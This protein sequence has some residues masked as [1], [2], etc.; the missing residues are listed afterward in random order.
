MTSQPGNAWAKPGSQRYPN[1]YTVGRWPGSA[2]PAGLLPSGTRG[3]A[4]LAGRSLCFVL[5]LA[6]LLISPMAAWAR[7]EEPAV[8]KTIGHFLTPAMLQSFFPGADRVGGTEGTPPAAAVYKADRLIGYIFSTWDVTRSRGFADRPLVL[9]VGLDLTGRITGAKL[10]QHNEAIGILGLRDEDFR[11]FPEQFAGFNVNGGTVVVQ[12]PALMSSGRGDASRQQA[13]QQAQVDA[14]AHAT[15]SSVMMSDAIIRGARIVA[16][17]RGIAGAASSQRRVDIDRFEPADWR[18]LEASGAIA[19]LRLAY[20]DVLGKLREHG[21][22]RI[23][24]VDRDASAGDS[25]LDLYIALLTPAAIGINVLGRMRYDLY[26]YSAERGI[27]NQLLLV[28]ANGRFSVLSRNGD[29]A[30]LAPIQLVQ[31]ARTIRLSAGQI[32]TQPF[33]QADNAPPLTEQAVAFIPG[34][35]GLDPAASWQIQLL[36]PGV[37]ADGR[38]VFAEFT[39]PY[40]LPESYLLKSTTESA[41]IGDNADDNARMAWTAIWRARYGE[42]AILG[43][44]LATLATILFL[45]AP[46]S[47]RPRLHRWIRIVFLSWTLIWLGWYAGAQLTVVLAI[48]WIHSLV[49]DFRWDYLLADPLIAILLGFTLISMVFWG[50]AA[51]CG[52]LCPFGALQE[53]TNRIARRLRIPQL[54][55]PAALHGRLVL[56]KYGLFVALL[57]VSFVS[58]DLAMAGT[59]VEPFKA[60]IILHFMTRWSL[61]VYAAALIS[62]SLFVERFYCRFA[63]PLGAGLAILGR[64]RVFN[65][66]KRHPECGSRCHF[67]ET[68][69]P[70]GAIRHSGHIDMNECFFCLDCQVAYYDDHVCPPMVWRRKLSEQPPAARL[71]GVRPGTTSR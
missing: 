30:D 5:V 12:Q 34:D 40:R 43:V 60:A 19:H 70:T 51:F 23:A 27:R 65:T 53:L 25:F 71:R 41:A 54:R 28:A 45:Q 7:S 22:I 39:L 57:G 1:G 58:W 33:L 55:I 36:V 49:T 15:T 20:S 14:I 68:I 56:P 11:H 8:G 17:S 10:V 44:A 52:W 21:A 61:V 26:S 62:A 6:F 32:K 24:G 2:A 64:V 38:T 4:R 67:C 16:R 47:R 31:G 9:L 66:L 59:E 63:C 37:T 69:C 13:Q 3:K 35:A 50:R 29:H 46:I 42:I 18:R 48:T